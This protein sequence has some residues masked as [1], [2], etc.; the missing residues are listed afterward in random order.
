MDKIIG[1]VG[2]TPKGEYNGSTI[3]E[4]LDVVSFE[5][6]SYV[7]KINDNNQPLSNL[8]AWQLN[9]EKG[10]KGD[11]GDAIDS[12]IY[13]SLTE[14]QKQD[15]ADRLDVSGKVDEGDTRAVSGNEVNKYMNADGSDAYNYNGD[16][17]VNTSSSVLDSTGIYFHVLTNINNNSVADKVRFNCNISG[18]ATLIQYRSNGSGGIEIYR[19]SFTCVAGINEFDVNINVQI[20]D[21][22]GVYAP[23]VVKRLASGGTGL[24]IIT[25]STST[26]SI[27]SDKWNTPYSSLVNMG[28]SFNIHIKEIK[29]GVLKEVVKNSD[30]NIVPGKNKFDKSIMIILN[31]IVDNVGGIANVSGAKMSRTPLL[32]N[33]TYSFKLPKYLPNSGGQIRFVDA[34]LNLI[35]TISSATFLDSNSGGKTFTTPLNTAY[36]EN[37]IYFS[38]GGF[39][40]ITDTFQIEE[41]QFVTDYQPYKQVIDKIDGYEL[42][43]DSF[44]NVIKAN[45]NIV[46]LGDSITA[47]TNENDY[48]VKIL[49]KIKFNN[50]LR[51]ARSGATWT[52]TAETVYDIT[53]NGGSTT[54][55][56]V[57]WNQINKLKHRTDNEEF[58]IPTTIFISAGTNDFGRP[59]GTYST[60]FTGTILDKNANT[61]TDLYKAIRFNIELLLSYYP[62]VRILLATPIQR[63]I[64]DNSTIFEIGNIIQECSNTLSIKNYRQDREVGIYGY[65]EVNQDI[66][67]YDN[68]HPNVAGA[69]KIADYIS[70]KFISDLNINQ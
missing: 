66:F 17:I 60:A 59:K 36:I 32:P 53:S 38:A 48:V 14:D 42:K 11:K 69:N 31:K 4:Y 23:N 54:P 49:E 47:A 37:N 9:A 40:D 57:I 51:L 65:N 46:F 30:L 64:A 12:I 21:K 26:T 2:Q 56:N 28:I 18:T 68:L 13:D 24:N 67:L 52:N 6:S 29:E 34:D 5:G 3:Y 41:G 15:I 50:V 63:G 10:G 61:I 62:N 27:P 16:S 8:D 1:K 70:K 39:T 55:D 33:T 20:G 43:Q 44:V 22:F 35:S 25:Y 58:P 45:E 19:Q 7:S